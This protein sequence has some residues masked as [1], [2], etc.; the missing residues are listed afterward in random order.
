MKS[1]PISVT[2]HNGILSKNPQSST[3]VTISCGNTVC[4]AEPKPAAFIMVDIK[5]CTML[6]RAIIS[7]KP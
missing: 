5:P 4:A 2:A 3:A 6:N 1:P 7:S